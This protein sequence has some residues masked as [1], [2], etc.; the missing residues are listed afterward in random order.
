MFKECGNHNSFKECGNHNSK[1]FCKA[2][3]AYPFS[4]IQKQMRCMCVFLFWMEIEYWVPHLRTICISQNQKQHDA[5]ELWMYL[6][7]FLESLCVSCFL[8]SS[9]SWVCVRVCV[10]ARASSYNS[11]PFQL[12]VFNISAEYCGEVEEGKL[13]PLFILGN[14][15]VKFLVPVTEN[16]I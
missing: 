4:K 5:R 13:L 12:W 14:P 11:S 15:S 1:S 6:S 3:E 16:K 9:D 8:F 7:T 10:C 2:T